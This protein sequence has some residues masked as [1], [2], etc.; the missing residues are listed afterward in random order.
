[1]EIIFNLFVV[2][3]VVGLTALVAYL[4]TELNI[5]QDRINDLEFLYDLRK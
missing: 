2:T 5:A 4:K 1:M 3:L